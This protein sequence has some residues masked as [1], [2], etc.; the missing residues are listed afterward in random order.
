MKKKMWV[1]VGLI[2][3]AVAWYAF[4]P[5]LLFVNKSVSENFPASSVSASTVDSTVAPKALATGQFKGY[6][7]ETE[8]DAGIYEVNGKRVLRV[9]R[10]KTSNGPDV[11]VYLVAAPDAKDD[12]TVKNSGFIDLGSMKGNMGDQ[13]YD[14]PGNPDLNKYQAVTI[15]CA[16][17]NV[18]F[19]TAPLSKMAA[20]TRELARGRFKGYAHETEGTAEIFDVEGSRVLRLTNFK[21][22]NGPDVHVYLVAAPDAKDDATVKKAGFVDLGSMKGN[23]GDQNYEVPDNVDLNTY[24][25]V[26]IWCARFNVNF[27][28][29]PL[30]AAR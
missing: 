26:T 18:N 19:G 16:R 10:F 11:H 12:A 6:A 21:T 28:T 13:N 9:T 30:A 1:G 15:W 8:G 23:V 20:G 17:F 27:A 4:R 5:E 29:A 22:S 24:Q 14:I 2:L 7:H 3:A 25:A